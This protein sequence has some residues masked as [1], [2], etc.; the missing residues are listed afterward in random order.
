MGTDKQ[1]YLAVLSTKQENQ[2]SLYFKF[3]EIDSDKGEIIYDFF[4]FMVIIDHSRILNTDEKTTYNSLKNEKIDHEEDNH[5]LWYL[6]KIISNFNSLILNK[7]HRIDK[8]MLP[9]YFSEFEWHFNHRHRTNFITK[10]MHYI[11]SS[12]VMMRKVIVAAMNAYAIKR[13]VISC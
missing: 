13:V 7:Y 8:R 9:L 3:K 6:N 10:I 12:F 4:K 2:Y 11:Q 1:P 5:R